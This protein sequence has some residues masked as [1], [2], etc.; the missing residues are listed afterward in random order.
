[1]MTTELQRDYIVPKPAPAE[2]RAMPRVES[3]HAPHTLGDC[4]AYLTG[5]AAKPRR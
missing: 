4:P 5:R 3:Y 1:M 2:R